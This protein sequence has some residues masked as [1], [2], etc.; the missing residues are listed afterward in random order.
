MGKMQGFSFNC[1]ESWQ[2]YHRADGPIAKYVRTP[3]K[4]VRRLAGSEHQV[5][6]VHDMHQ[7]EGASSAAQ[8]GVRSLP[9]VN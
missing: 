1:Q 3:L 7:Y 6:V 8:H 4:P 5:M 9:A 2:A